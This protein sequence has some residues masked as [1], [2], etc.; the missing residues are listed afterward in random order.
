MLGAWGWKERSIAFLQELAS[1][2]YA[3]GLVLKIRHLP[4]N[5]LL[6]Y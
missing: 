6:I 4:D 3:T 5:I 1:E 2:D